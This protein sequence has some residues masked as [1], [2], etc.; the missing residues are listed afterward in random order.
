MMNGFFA[1]NGA[2]VSE[3]CAKYMGTTVG[4][5]CSKFAQCKQEAKVTESYFL[6]NPGEISTDEKAI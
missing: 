1:E 4:S 2:L 3:E 5:P 6:G